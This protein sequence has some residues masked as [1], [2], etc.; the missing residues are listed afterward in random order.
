MLFDTVW[1]QLSIGVPEDTQEKVEFLT[2]DE[3]L[4]ALIDRAY[5]PEFLGG[6]VEDSFL[7]NLDDG[8]HF[9]NLQ[10]NDQPNPFKIKNSHEDHQAKLFESPPEK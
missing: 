5:L 9:A 7:T 4:Y 3:E 1:N 10:K 2:D 8:Q 6:D